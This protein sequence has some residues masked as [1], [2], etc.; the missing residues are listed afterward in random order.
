MPTGLDIHDRKHKCYNC[1][2]CLRTYPLKL[3]NKKKKVRR[4]V[5]Y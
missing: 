4:I 5:N 1:A 2:E 3:L